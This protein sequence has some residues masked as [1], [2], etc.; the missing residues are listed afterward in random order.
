MAAVM[1]S[2]RLQVAWAA[3]LAAS[4]AGCA[5][6]Q[7][8]AGAIEVSIRADGVLREVS[9]PAGT[10]AVQALEQ[11]GVELG[12][13]DRVD[14]AGFI[15][16]TDGTQITVT[17]VVERFEVES[18]TLPF[19]QQTIRNEA[20]P[21]GTTRLLQ[22]GENGLQ[23]VT[24]RILEEEGVEASRVPAQVVVV[25]EPR[26]EIVMIGAQS[27]YTPIPLEGTLAYVSGG[28]AW[29]VSGDSA[30]RR[31]LVVSG[32][33]DGRILKLS[34]DGTWLLFS[35]QDPEEPDAINSLW[36]ISTIDPEAREFSLGVENVVHFADWLPEVPYSTIAY[37]TVEPRPAAPGWQANNDL[38]LVTFSRTEH[39]GRVSRR[40]TLIPTNS[41]GQYGWW[42][43]QFVWS[44]DGVRLAFA[45][46]DSIG[47]VDLRS[48]ALQ[49]WIEVPPLQTLGEWAW[50][51]GVAWG[52]DDRTLFV[53]QHG[54][55]VGLEGPGASPVFHLLAVSAPLDAGHR[56]AERTGMFA[57]PATSPA[58]VLPSGEIAY[59]VAFLQ[60]IDPLESERSG[61]VV[62]VM[63][64]DGS[65]RRNLFPPEGE[66]GLSGQT[67]VW[68]PQASYIAVLY[69]GDLWV[70]DVASGIGQRLTGDGQTTAVDWKP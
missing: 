39:S 49:T 36:V 53:V 43:T 35:R 5:A 37:S 10:T 21:Q 4:L 1:T 56:M 44:G 67:P 32:D 65:N 60:A 62:A 58:K 48:P 3:L 25:Q 7:A 69:Q 46:P 27:S 6:P 29:R 45:R 18:V 23:E 12:T 16:V 26:P 22:E 13:L 40:R 9:V 19:E 52:Q 61:Y 31:P 70:V 14:P 30:N 38:Q 24:Y 2:G 59:S 8:P 47:V 41:G 42:G 57:S 28:N 66:I 50:L 63:D 11:A 20:L 68:S 15:V 55:P 54:D 17:R 64:R 34:P 51:P 33:L